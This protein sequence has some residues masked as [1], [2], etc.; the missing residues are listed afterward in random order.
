M[1][2]DLNWKQG[3]KEL[4]SGTKQS[5]AIYPKE[6]IT[7]HSWILIFFIADAR[8][9]MRKFRGS[10]VEDNRERANDADRSLAQSLQAY[11]LLRPKQDNWRRISYK[12][13]LNI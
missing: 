3:A 4:F 7:S 13:L 1:R 8:N 10:V 9:I 11:E 12:Y 2:I 5:Q 6:T